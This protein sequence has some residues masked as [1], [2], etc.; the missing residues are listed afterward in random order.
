M[1]RKYPENIAVRIG[2]EEPL[3]HR[4]YAGA[5]MLLVPARFEPCGLSQLYAMRYGTVPIARRTG[6][7]ADTVI[8]ATPQS[9]A[10][11]TATGFTFSKPTAGA[12]IE[13][14]NR[15][16]AHYAL[17]LNWRRLQLQAMSR[18]HGWSRSA[19]KYLSLYRSLTGIVEPTIPAIAEP[20]VTIVA[21]IAI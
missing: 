18:D 14:M 8:D 13:A 11:R 10:D 15:A 21:P 7:L 3:A 9:I 12:I 2:Y 4:L 6:G 1:A 16:L 20:D 17:P 5:D 19:A